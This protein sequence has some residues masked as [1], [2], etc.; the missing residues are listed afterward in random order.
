MGSFSIDLAPI[1]NQG[2]SYANILLIGL[3]GL[4]ALIFGF[5]LFRWLWGM[6]VNIVNQL[7]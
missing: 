2:F 5:G 1:L 7:G 6:L 3:G 4:L